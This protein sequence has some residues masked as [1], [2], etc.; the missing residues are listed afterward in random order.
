MLIDFHLIQLFRSTIWVHNFQLITARIFWV[1]Y[2][3]TCN[4]GTVSI[5]R[6]WFYVPLCFGSLFVLG[7]CPFLESSS[8]LRGPGSCPVWGW[9]WECI[10]E[11]CLH[12]EEW[13][14][15][16]KFCRSPL[17]MQCADCINV[18]VLGPIQKWVAFVVEEAGQSFTCTVHVELNKCLF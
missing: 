8:D 6:P 18:S 14:T 11:P 17:Q 13:N 9:E 4:I 10:W 2:N 16:Y 1:N 3:W 7:S 12:G 15:L 5:R